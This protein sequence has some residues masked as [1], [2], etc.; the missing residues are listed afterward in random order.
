MSR[1]SRRHA[2]LFAISAAWFAAICWYWDTTIPLEPSNVVALDGR[3]VHIPGVR[4]DVVLLHRQKQVPDQRPG[5]QVFRGSA[6]MTV[7][8]GPVEFCDPRTGRIL[9]Q[10]LDTADQILRFSFSEPLWAAVAR[11]DQLRMVDLASGRAHWEIPLNGLIFADFA[12]QDRILLVQREDNLTAY[13]RESG[14]VLW[15]SALSMTTNPW[16]GPQHSLDLFVAHRRIEEMV[17][18]PGNQKAQTVFKFRIHDARTGEPDARFQELPSRPELMRSPDGR[19]LTIDTQGNTREIFDAETGKRLWKLSG[20]PAYAME[21]SLDGNE[22][23]LRYVSAEKRIGHA[24]WSA[25]DGTLI[26]ELPRGASPVAAISVGQNEAV[27]EMMVYARTWPPVVQTCLDKLGL[28]H[29]NKPL[30]EHR[31]LHILADRDTRAIHG[32]LPGERLNFVPMASQ[33]GFAAY[34]DKQMA[35][36]QLPPERNWLWLWTRGLIPP[37]VLAVLVSALADWRTRRV[38]PSSVTDLDSTAGSTET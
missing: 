24:R 14:N 25:V 9:S 11:G 23:L 29:L 8:T 27:Y 2:V 28:S 7:Q 34:T 16:T 3:K 33:A 20:H 18:T 36:F 10:C 17:G 1:P 37:V 32:I 22:L 19:W 30:T 15:T 6:W 35:Y 12:S 26:A 31:M 38:Q 5:T 4:S 13:D 21:F